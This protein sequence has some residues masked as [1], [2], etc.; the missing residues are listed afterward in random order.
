MEAD[1]EG[2]STEGGTTSAS[3]HPERFTLGNLFS[4]PIK[5]ATGDEVDGEAH[6]RVSIPIHVPIH[7]S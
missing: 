7:R 1:R 3:P 4:R 6:K 2:D 5:L